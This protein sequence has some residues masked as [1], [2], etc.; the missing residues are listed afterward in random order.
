MNNLNDDS[1]F[2]KGGVLTD[3]KQRAEIK[4]EVG[5]DACDGSWYIDLK[6]N[7]GHLRSVMS[8]QQAM[9]MALGILSTLER[10]GMTVPMDWKR[11]TPPR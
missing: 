10:F 9:N 11:W 2:R 7:G 1:F 8:P 6:G 3:L 4:T 5:R